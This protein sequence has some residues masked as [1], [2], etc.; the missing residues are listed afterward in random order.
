MFQD[1][2]IHQ[3]Q[4]GWEQLFYGQIVSSWNIVLIITVTTKSVTPFSTQGLSLSIGSTY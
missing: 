1:M 4:I 2:F 3:Q